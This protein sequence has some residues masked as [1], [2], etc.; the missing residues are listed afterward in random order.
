MILKIKPGALGARPW[1]SWGVERA[2][3]GGHKAR[4]F[5]LQTVLHWYWDSFTNYILNGWTR[6]IRKGR[7][8]GGVR[9]RSHWPQLY[10][11]R[12]NDAQADAQ[13]SGEQGGKQGPFA[14]ARFSSNG[15][16]GRA[17]GPVEKG[18]DDEV[19]GSEPSPAVSGQ[20]SPHGREILHCQEGIRGQIA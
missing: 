18:K 17:A 19:E 15:E 7:K 20:N 16:Q 10:D 13:S 11:Y 2:C 5:S 3:D 8:K 14:A 4:H 9:I 6:Q 12:K 1:P